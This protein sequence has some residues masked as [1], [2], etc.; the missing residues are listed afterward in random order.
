MKKLFLLLTFLNFSAVAQSISLQEIRELYQEGESSEEAAE[1]LQERLESVGEEE[2]V[3]LAYKAS[4]TMLMAKYAFSPFR[5]LSY[6]NKGKELLQQA[7][8]AAP[9]NVEIRFLRFALQDST[10][11][12]LGYKDFMEEDKEFLLREIPGLEDEGL[13]ELVLPFL[14]NSEYLTEDEKKLMA[15]N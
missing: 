3:L 10:P 15:G 13:R 12:F 1:A 14:L 5:K 11:G 4:G 7:V 8:D 2:P 9:D 6:F